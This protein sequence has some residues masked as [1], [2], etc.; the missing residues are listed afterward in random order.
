MNTNKIQEFYMDLFKINHIS[1]E[2][3]FLK[4]F[5]LE[6]RAIEVWLTNENSQPSEIEE[7]INL[8]QYNH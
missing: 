3:I 5:N 4:T 7:R 1:K 8:T 6:F 2:F